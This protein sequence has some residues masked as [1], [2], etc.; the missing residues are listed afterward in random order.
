MQMD[1]I[2]HSCRKRMSLMH[3]RASREGLTSH[4]CVCLVMVH[5]SMVID[6]I[7]KLSWKSR[8]VDYK[9][10]TVHQIYQIQLSLNLCMA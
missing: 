9:A 4:K 7:L 6:W 1:N 5:R 8:G 2:S 3:A 10:R